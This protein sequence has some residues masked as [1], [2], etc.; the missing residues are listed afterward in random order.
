MEKEKQVIKE[1]IK[2]LDQISDTLLSR[3][4]EEVTLPQI[5]PK[6]RI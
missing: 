5:L 3:N 1:R 4:E 2:R 6:R